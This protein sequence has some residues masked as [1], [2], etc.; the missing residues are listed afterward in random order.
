MN[1]LIQHD[2]R[3]RPAAGEISSMMNKY[4]TYGFW[5]WDNSKFNSCS[6]I[7]HTR[8]RV[9]SVINVRKTVCVLEEL[10][11]KTRIELEGHSLE[12][13]EVRLKI[14]SVNG[15]SHS[16]E[17]ITA[18]LDLDLSEEMFARTNEFSFLNAIITDISSSGGRKFSILTVIADYGNSHFDVL[19]SFIGMISWNTFLQNSSLVNLCSILELKERVYDM[20]IE[21]QHEIKLPY[22]LSN[23]VQNSFE[24]ALESLFPLVVLDSKGVLFMHPLCMGLLK[25]WNLLDKN[26]FGEQFLRHFLN[27]LDQSTMSR[28]VRLYT[29]KHSEIL[30]KLGIPKPHFI[31]SLIRMSR[32]LSLIRSLENTVVS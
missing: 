21:A 20:I 29:S 15:K 2:S 6:H 11:R 25:S 16:W 26:I 1:F 5:N 13:R 19:L 24:I 22:T 14:L 10:G 12:C 30:S 28:P 31:K 3:P 8:E 32:L 27:L 17:Y 9:T 4:F 18:F 23:Q 7:L